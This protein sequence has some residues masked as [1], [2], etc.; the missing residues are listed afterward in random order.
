MITCISNREAGIQLLG[1]RVRLKNKKETLPEDYV[2]LPS[3]VKL[4]RI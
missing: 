3:R 2:F 4:G 1:A